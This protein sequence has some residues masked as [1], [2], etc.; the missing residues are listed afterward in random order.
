MRITSLFGEHRFLRFAGETAS[1]SPESEPRG[2]E[3]DGLH[4]ELSH[5]MEQQNQSDPTGEWFRR[6]EGP[7]ND[8]ENTQQNLLQQLFGQG[9]LPGLEQ[10]Q[11][12][13]GARPFS[14]AANYFNPQTG[15]FGALA[16]NGNRFYVG[17]PPQPW[18]A[19]HGIHFDGRA[20]HP[21]SFYGPRVGPPHLPQPMAPFFMGPDGAYP[22]ARAL[23]HGVERARIQAPVRDQLDGLLDSVY[24]GRRPIVWVDAD[25]KPLADQGPYVYDPDRYY[26]RTPRGNGTQNA[27]QQRNNG[28]GNGTA[29]RREDNNR[30]ND[31]QPINPDINIDNFDPRKMSPARR[32]EWR[33]AIQSALDRM[34]P[35]EQA[36]EARMDR[37]E[38]DGKKGTPEYQREK[39]KL[40]TIVKKIMDLDMKLE[41][42]TKA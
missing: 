22:D 9:L 21:Y 34:K 24:N 31:S 12:F 16:E 3:I 5:V 11:V 39:E 23:M 33:R 8:I 19:L 15:E 25:G 37:M 36:Q 27:P 13:G 17:N 35:E 30:Y 20:L 10:P 28:S 26:G 2:N 41:K 14:N 38:K 42:I 18:D 7:Y 32:E 6:I 40:E 29:E 4:A 1:F